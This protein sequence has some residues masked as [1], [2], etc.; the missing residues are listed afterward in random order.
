MSI[1]NRQAVLKIFQD[2][3]GDLIIRPEPGVTLGCTLLKNENGYRI[4]ITPDG[5][6]CNEVLD[7]VPE[8]EFVC[9]MMFAYGS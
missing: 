2:K 6:G 3:N 7:G 9:G 1:I 8:I 4:F 5:C